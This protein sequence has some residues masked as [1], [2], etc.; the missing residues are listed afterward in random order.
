MSLKV[1]EQR[2]IAT[3][4]FIV[5]AWILFL[6]LSVIVDYGFAFQQYLALTRCV[7]EGVMLASQSGNFGEATVDAVRGRVLG[8]IKAYAQFADVYQP[9]DP[10]INVQQDLIDNTVSVRLRTE[11][12]GVLLL[13]LPF[14][15]EAHGPY[16]K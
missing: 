7:H 14:W 5:V 15:I 12:R 13:R 1:K 3:L 2:G 8:S 11:F 16:L 6:F 9:H 10:V 4:E